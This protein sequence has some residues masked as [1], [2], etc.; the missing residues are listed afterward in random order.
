MKNLLGSLYASVREHRK[1]FA[2]PNG[3]AVLAAALLS[4]SGVAHA[5]RTYE[6]KLEGSP[7]L[8][9]S[10]GG[11]YLVTGSITTDGTVGKLNA[12]NVL[13]WTLSVTMGSQAPVSMW[14]GHASDKFSCGSTSCGLNTDAAGNLYFNYNEFGDAE[15]AGAYN[16]PYVFFTGSPGW[17]SIFV[18]GEFPSSVY[19]YGYGNTLIGQ[20]AAVPEPATTALLLCGGLLV[21]AMRQ[22]EKI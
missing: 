11:S 18:F 15:F 6:V 9:G 17:G 22:R 4:V 2:V 12:S 20:A 8:N 19:A 7:T 5:T 10:V 3:A 21:M 13:D 16:S 14:A 1:A